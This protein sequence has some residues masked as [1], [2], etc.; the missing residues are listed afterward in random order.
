MK[1]IL[2]A[3]FIGLLAAIAWLLA[4]FFFADPHSFINSIAFAPPD[5]VKS[6]ILPHETAAF[7]YGK[8][9]Q[10]AHHRLFIWLSIFIWWIPFSIAAWFVLG[11][12]KFSA[13]ADQNTSRLDSAGRG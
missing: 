1:R 7:L 10:W 2:T 6:Q 12:T 3:G 13:T 11:W 4:V 8:E 5:F 9:S